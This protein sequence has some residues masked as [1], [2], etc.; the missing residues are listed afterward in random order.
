MRYSS[1]N[2]AIKDEAIILEAGYCSIVLKNGKVYT[3]RV[4]HLNKEEV[5][6][7]N[8]RLKKQRISISELSE[9]IID[10]K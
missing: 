10:Y 7:E 4:L 3:G 8:M 2:K 1:V 9:L 5:V 6:F